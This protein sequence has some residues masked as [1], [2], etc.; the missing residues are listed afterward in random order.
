MTAA[1]SALQPRGLG[2]ADDA[3]LTAVA[4]VTMLERINYL[5]S[6]GVELPAEEITDR[7]AE[8]IM[9]AFGET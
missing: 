4:C 1:R 5:L 8:I 2:A 6:V 7:I 3:E 9:A